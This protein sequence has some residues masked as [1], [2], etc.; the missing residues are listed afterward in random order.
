MSGLDMSPGNYCYYTDA[1][2]FPGK[3]SRGN[4]F[5][6]C[7]NDPDKHV[8]DFQGTSAMVAGLNRQIG[9]DEHAADEIIISSMLASNEREASTC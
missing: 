3:H 2:H 7:R 8:L 9:V 4:V 5:I 1:D 6:I